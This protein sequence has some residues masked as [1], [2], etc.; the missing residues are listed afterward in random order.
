MIKPRPCRIVTIARSIR[1][2]LGLDFLVKTPLSVEVHLTGKF[3]FPRT[4]LLVI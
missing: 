1:H 4:N 3:F 2:C